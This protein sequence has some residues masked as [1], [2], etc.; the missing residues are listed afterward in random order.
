MQIIIAQI[1]VLDIKFVKVLFSF[2]A[3]FLI[4]GY[5]QTQWTFY[6]FQAG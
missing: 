6:L 2:K 3:S 1:N 5:L 4:T